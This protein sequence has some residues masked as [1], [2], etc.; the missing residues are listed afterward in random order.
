METDE[1]ALTTP[2]KSFQN[3]TSKKLAK[4]PGSEPGFFARSFKRTTYITK[5]QKITKI[6]FSF[7]ASLRNVY[8]V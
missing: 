6:Y 1:R 7:R 5:L 4:K 2:I 3:R 8:D